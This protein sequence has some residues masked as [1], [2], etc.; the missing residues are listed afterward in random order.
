MSSILQAYSAAA[1]Q[2]QTTLQPIQ[3][4]VAGI[5]RKLCR[6]LQRSACGQHHGEYVPWRVLMNDPA[7][8]KPGLVAAV[9][10]IGEQ[11]AAEALRVL[12]ERIAPYRPYYDAMELINPTSPDVSVRK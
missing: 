7:V 10:K 11:F 2:L 4:R 8:N 3:H 12:G 9:D 6:A 5:L 1:T